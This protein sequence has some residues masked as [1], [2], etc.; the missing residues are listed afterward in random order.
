[1]AVRKASKASFPQKGMLCANDFIFI[2]MVINL[3]ILLAWKMCL[4]W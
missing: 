3:F 4:L 1:M 2:S